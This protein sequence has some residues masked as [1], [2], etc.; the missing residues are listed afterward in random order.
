MKN[1]SHQQDVCSQ[2]I[3]T[4][5]HV[6]PASLQH[7]GKNVIKEHSGREGSHLPTLKFSV[8]WGLRALILYKTGLGWENKH[9][10]IYTF[11]KLS[12]T[13]DCCVVLGITF[14]CFTDIETCY[15]VELFSCFIVSSSC[16]Y[17]P[18]AC[19]AHCTQRCEMPANI[20][21]PISFQAISGHKWTL[22][23]I[24]L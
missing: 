17:S 13:T 12:P 15:V 5:L 14:V 19:S 1:T 18:G 22:A 24:Q 4:I 21:S 11:K 6:S 10:W 8:Q 7:K 16:G 2:F 20:F 23:H 9:S 3:F